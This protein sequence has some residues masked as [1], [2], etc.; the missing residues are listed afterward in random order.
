MVKPLEPVWIET[1]LALAIHDRQLAEHGGP[2]GVRDVSALESAL[3]RPRHQWTYGEADCCALAAAYAYGVA[4]NH[5]FTD[6][7][8]RTAWVLAR[9]F[10]TLN[11]ISIAFRPG[12]AI[13]AVL[14]LAAGELGEKE[15]AEWFRTRRT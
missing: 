7:N 3:A 4:R 11:D 9:L 15:L 8:K 10:L 6:G 2:V 1:E 12:E 5:P 14:Q 13:D